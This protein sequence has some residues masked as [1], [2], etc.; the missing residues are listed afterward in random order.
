[1]F[2]KS[3]LLVLISALGACSTV[4]DYLLGKDNTPAPA[5]LEPIKPK[6]ALTEKWTVPVS[7]AKK[8]PI[9]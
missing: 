3:L 6:V 9:I 4:D 1:M 7:N 8:Q 5:E 2:K